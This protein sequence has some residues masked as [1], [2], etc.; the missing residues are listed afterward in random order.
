MQCGIMGF[1]HLIV[2]KGT[3]WKFIRQTHR[4]GNLLNF[5]WYVNQN[6]TLH[7]TYMSPKIRNK[8]G[9]TEKRQKK[10]K[11]EKKN[12]K[13][14]MR[15]TMGQGL[16]L[17]PHGKKVL[18]SI[19]TWGRVFLCG[20]CMFSPCLWVLRFPP[21]SNHVQVSTLIEFLAQN[22]ELVTGH[23]AVAAHCSSRMGLMQRPNF[24]VHVWP[25]KYL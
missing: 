3:R 23:R 16:A 6:L 22:L 7:P 11:K 1:V 9:K 17:L 13:Y 10:E 15:D 24:T 4:R 20:V 19:S 5:Y 14:I 2:K 18:V 12:N 25:I 21:P 8:G